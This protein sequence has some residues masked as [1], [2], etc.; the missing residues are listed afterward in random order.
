M[1][2][3]DFKNTQNENVSVCVC[4]Y[5]CV[6]VCAERLVN[7]KLEERFWEEGGREK[8]WGGYNKTS[9]VLGIFILSSQMPSTQAITL[10]SL[11]IHISYT[12]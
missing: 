10:L 9:K 4:V 5:V 12:F 7:T 1:S 11:F 3:L 2:Y 6:C 8:G